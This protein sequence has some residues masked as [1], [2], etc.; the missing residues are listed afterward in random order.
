MQPMAESGLPHTRARAGHW[1]T[2]AA[3]VA[4]ACGLAVLIQPA[5]ATT[6]EAS[7]PGAAGPAAG[8]AAA[9]P[10]PES[11]DY[12]LDCGPHPTVVTHQVELDLDRDGRAETVAAVR[13][14]AGGGTPPNGVY[15]LAGPADGSGAAEVTETLVDPAD[16]MIV[17]E[18]RISGGTVT[19]LLLGYSGDDV[20]RSDPDLHGE[21]SWYWDEGRLVVE[22]AAPESTVSL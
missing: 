15:L 10:D 17:E 4:A 19:A 11:A 13:C 16:G 9:A 18:L 3:A 20:P 8:E 7:A 22:Q 12:P 14:D 1:L 2:T 6:T 5:G 21:A